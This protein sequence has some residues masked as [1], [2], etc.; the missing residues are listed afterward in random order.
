[1]GLKGGLRLAHACPVGHVGVHEFTERQCRT[2]AA[3][4]PQSRGFL[5]R[6]SGI[7]M[8]VGILLTV[9]ATSHHPRYR[10]QACSAG[11]LRI[12]T[13]ERD[14]GPERPLGLHHGR[15]NGRSGVNS[16]VAAC[17]VLTGASAGESEPPSLRNGSR[18]GGCLLVKLHERASP[19]LL[20]THG[21]SLRFGPAT[22]PRERKDPHATCSRVEE[23][24]AQKFPIPPAPVRHDWS[25][26]RLASVLLERCHRSA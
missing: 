2:R 8:W 16:G 19:G 1:M 15:T 25:S 23:I 11:L 24:F 20:V 7:R 12:A 6:V 21:R 10:Y 14:A 5:P 18:Q 26:L 22:R 13:P 3:V 17:S 4:L 9:T